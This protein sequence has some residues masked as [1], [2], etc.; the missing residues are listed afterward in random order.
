MNL[1][2]I[3]VWISYFGK[4]WH[5]RLFG[6]LYWL[7]ERNW[8]LMAGLAWCSHPPN[9]FLWVASLFDLGILVVRTERYDWIF[10]KQ[11]IG[12]R[13]SELFINA[14]HVGLLL[15]PKWLRLLGHWPRRKWM[16]RHELFIYWFIFTILHLRFFTWPFQFF[17]WHLFIDP[18]V[19]NNF[20][21]NG[22]RGTSDTLI[23]NLIFIQFV[24]LLL[25]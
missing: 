10:C 19:V 23:R 20:W 5:I 14:T 15:L 9:W 18:V 22:F 21:F 6:L 1:Q 24:L 2:R 25:N 4:Y 13:L 11:S 3:E 7:R 17:G 8:I 12:W 16:W